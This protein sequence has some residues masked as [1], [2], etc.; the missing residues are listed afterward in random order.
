MRSAHTEMDREAIVTD[1]DPRQLNAAAVS[2][3]FAMASLECW[4][5]HGD[6]MASYALGNALADSRN[7]A[8]RVQG[9][10]FLSAAAYGEQAHDEPPQM[11]PDLCNTLAAGV[12]HCRYGLPEA[13]ARLGRILCQSGSAYSRVRGWGQFLQAFLGGLWSAKSEGYRACGPFDD[14]MFSALPVE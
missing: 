10:I 6:Q 9:V 11:T 2:E 7:P 13:H 3:H 5:R 4:S 1:A 12:V 14:R 8:E